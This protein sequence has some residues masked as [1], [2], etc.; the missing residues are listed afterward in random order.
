MDNPIRHF[1]ANPNKFEF[2]KSVAD[3]FPDMARRSIPNFYQFHAMHA[4][5]VARGWYRDGMR[6]ADLGASRG[7]F[8][9]ACRNEFDVDAQYTL[10]TDLSPHM[11]DYL[12][13]DFPRAT[14]RK[15]DLADPN[16]LID[17]EPFDVINMTYVLQFIQPSK[18]FNT[19]S[20]ILTRLRPGGLFIFGCKDAGSNPLDELLHESYI[21]FRTENGYT[22]EEIVAKTEALKNSMWPQDRLTIERWLTNCGIWNTRE[23]TRHSCFRTLVGVKTGG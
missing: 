4:A 16:A 23:T 5:I 10:M 21:D 1:P 14:V 11:V 8:I 18:Q 20:N 6:I 17:D 12:R 2:D 13:D 9:E 15:M 3:I 7:A 19:L 22:R